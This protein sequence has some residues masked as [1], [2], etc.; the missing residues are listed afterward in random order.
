MVQAKGG[1]RPNSLWRL[2]RVR[3][4]VLFCFVL[5]GEEGV[6]SGFRGLLRWVGQ[7]FLAC[8]A[9]RGSSRP[10]LFEF[11]VAGSARSFEVSIHSASQR[12]V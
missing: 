6:R 8:F 5:V 11:R 12:A 7:F 9:R 1:R 10:V 3:G 4:V 2:L